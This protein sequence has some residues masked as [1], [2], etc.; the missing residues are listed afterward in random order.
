MNNILQDME[1]LK[2]FLLKSTF[3]PFWFAGHQSASFRDVADRFNLSLSTLESVLRRV[4]QF[5][6]EM[7]NEFIRYPTE[8]EKQRTQRY[9]MENKGFPG[10]IGNNVIH[11]NDI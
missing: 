9:Y 3:S 7:R 1:G 4:T 8:L 2:Q 5:L 6:Y 11:F 10:V